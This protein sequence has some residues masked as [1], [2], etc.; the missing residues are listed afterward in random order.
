MKELDFTLTWALDD[1]AA[2]RHSARAAKEE[3][4][5]DDPG[6]QNGKRALDVREEQ[7]VEETVELH[8]AK[9]RSMELE[10]L[11]LELQMERNV[12]SCEVSIGPAPKLPPLQPWSHG[13]LSHAL[14]DQPELQ[15][16][17][18]GMDNG[19]PMSWDPGN[20]E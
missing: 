15:D 4:S 17:P 3:M 11:V 18:A 2:G 1:P 14:P 8:T 6:D 16:L 13:G 20:L 5:V 12:N 7:T 10:C 19:D 9:M